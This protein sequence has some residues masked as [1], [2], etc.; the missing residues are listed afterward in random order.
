MKKLFILLLILPVAA[1]AQQSARSSAAPVSEDAA[2][3][4]KADS[5]RSAAAGS[6]AASPAAVRSSTLTRSYATAVAVIPAQESARSAG[7]K[8]APAVSAARVF[9]ADASAVRNAGPLKPVNPVTVCRGDIITRYE[10]APQTVVSKGSYPD[11]WGYDVL[12]V[13][14][15]HKAGIT[16]KGIRVAIIDGG[17]E[18]G[19]MIKAV[20]A[21]TAPDAE[22]YFKDTGGAV[23]NT[24]FVKEKIEEVLE[25]N[26]QNP[27][28]KIN[29][30]NLSFGAANA[31]D[32]VFAA[33]V[34]KAYSEGVLI[35]TPTGNT[36][37]EKIYF[38]ANAKETLAVG[39]LSPEMKPSVDS[40]Y[41][42]SYNKQVDFLV[43]GDSI[44]TLNSAGQPV[45]AW[46]TSLSA[47]FTS[48]L[49]ALASQSYIKSNYRLP[50]PETLVKM[51]RGC[52]GQ[53]PG[54]SAQR[55]GSGVPDAQCLAAY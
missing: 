37:K 49:A 47:A 2:R 55:Q 35:V 17:G 25:H 8:P 43:P 21:K 41:M 6:T 38:P 20:F 15:A 45:Y 29:I 22:I 14:E 52:S 5:S 1:A 7:K 11:N 50:E 18:H 54:I 10:S 33:V 32:D 3:L 24:I 31:W 48:G 44:A 51:L 39:S 34:S 36:S 16:G 13:E 19:A 26:R 40:A 42:P 27:S 28:K 9:K 23:T 4:Q 30:I 46:G 53:I 12:K